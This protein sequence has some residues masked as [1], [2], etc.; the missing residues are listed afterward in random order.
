MLVR[1]TCTMLAL[2][3]PL[4]AL[5]QDAPR[6]IIGGENDTVTQLG[7]IRDVV[8]LPR[9]F[10]VLEHDAPFIKVFDYTGRLLQTRG[11]SGSGPGEFRSPTSLALD[12]GQQRLFVVDASNARVTVYQL[13]DTLA[14]P[15]FLRLEDIGVRKI[16][17]LG[18]RIFGLA[19]NA[20]TILRELREEDE[21]IQVVAS[22]GEPRTN[23]PLGAHPLV[24]TRASDGPLLCDEA[25]NRVVAASAILG[26]VHVF[27]ATSR[28]QTT[29]S[30]SGFQRVTITV[31]NSSMTIAQPDGG[32]DGVLGLVAWNGV[33]QVVTER[34]GMLDNEPVSLGFAIAGVGAQGPGTLGARTRWRPLARTPTG[35]LCSQSDPA[36]SIALFGSGRCP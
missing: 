33:V 9:G 3:V 32:A 8:A 1:L 36:P 5:A 31:H 21:K 7:R 22:F 20:P 11:R 16:C 6:W 10:V 27:D 13:R 15:R 34:M 23:H 26:E 17:V 12:A 30:I 29:T 25:G 28:Q 4:S 18:T 19:R 14:T 24:R 35:A 2:A